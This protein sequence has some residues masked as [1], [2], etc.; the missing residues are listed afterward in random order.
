MSRVLSLPTREPQELEHV[1]DA[2]PIYGR[3]G[4]TLKLWPI[5]S[6][7]LRE[8]EL[9]GGLAGPIGVGAG[10]TLISLLASLALYRHTGR[11]VR[12]LLLIPAHM[13]GTL[14]AKVQ[15]AASSFY[16]PNE[17]AAVSLQTLTYSMLSRP[18]FALTLDK[19]KPNLIIAD[20]AHK[21]RNF[22]AARTLRVARAFAD[23]SRPAFVPLSGTLLAQSIKDFA[24]LLEW[25]LGEG[26]PL[27]R[28]ISPLGSWASVVDPDANPQAAD[29]VSVRDLVRRFGENQ[30]LNQDNARKALH[31][32]IRL[33][34]G[35]IATTHTDVGASLSV[36][37]RKLT[38]PK[39]IEVLLEQ[40]AEYWETPGGVIMDSASQ[41]AEAEREILQGFYYE[42]VW[43]QGIVDKD[44]VESRRSWSRA[45]RE[46]VK[47]RRP[48][49]DTEFLIRQATDL[50]A[51]P[52]GECRAAWESWET[53][54]LKPEPPRRIVWVSYYMIED[55]L[56]W[57]AS[58][59]GRIIW[60]HHNAMGEALQS[61]GIPYYG[62]G[63]DPPRPGEPGGG[64]SCAMSMAHAEGKDLF[65]WQES[66]VLCPM[67]SG[68]AWE[69]LLGRTHRAGQKADEVACWYYCH[70][71]RF[72][73]SFSRALERARFY[74]SQGM[75]QR[76]LYASHS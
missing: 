61:S 38:A 67:S 73:G 26:S 14:A 25:A 41:V 30:M 74:E 42:A 63:M 1:P 48:G 70:H 2:T 47:L 18:D 7:A 12:A 8:I 10:K 44:W 39:E 28:E 62:P 65:D 32:R 4:G 43:P 68:L 35:I 5:Q 60:F 75:R 54:R 56:K 53:E 76:L 36:C 3:P 29:W 16:M 50:G 23:K 11:E 46:T 69:Q 55:A 6:L 58:K 20:E 72:E 9:V 45:V 33:T 51:A 37:R 57:A 52:T 59:P 49:L 27:P 22:T 19:L 64:V 31:N 17:H 66:L 34:P 24:H 40:V 13:R 15:E 21:L 71:E